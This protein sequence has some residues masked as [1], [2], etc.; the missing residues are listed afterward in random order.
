MNPISNPAF[1]HTALQAYQVILYDRAL[2]PELFQLRARRVHRRGEY[3]LEAWVMQGMHALRFGHLVPGRSGACACE[4]LTD[5]PRSPVSGVVSAFLCAGERDYE[6]TL[7]RGSVRY[8]TSVQTEMLA[9][10]VYAATLR[11]LS[12]L[13]REND[14]VVARWRDDAGACLSLVDVQEYA[15]E[16]HCQSY[17]MIATGG[18]V[19]RTQTIFEHR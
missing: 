7:A 4:L 3:E 18:L 10:T 12:E 15:R 14:A 16:V 6:H 13:A 5:M 8:M 11:E 1:K 9:E 17:H 2:H 19:I